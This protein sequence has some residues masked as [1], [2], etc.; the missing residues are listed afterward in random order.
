MSESIIGL[1]NFSGSSRLPVILQTESAECGLACLAMV[2]SYHG[3]VVDLNTLRR[4]FPITLRGIDLV[5]LIAMAERLKFISNPVRLEMEELSQ[6]QRPA[7]L[8]WDLNHFVVLKDIQAKYIEIHDPSQGLCKLSWKEFSKHFTGVAVEL[9]PTSEFEK[10]DE[11]NTL[12]LKNFIKPVRG[13][14][15][16][17]LKILT[18]SLSLQ[19]FAVLTPF[20]MQWVVDEAIMVHDQHLVVVLSVGFLLLMLINISTTALRSYVVLYVSNL[21]SIQMG[22]HLFNH[23]I[24]L[25]LQYFERRHMGDIV[26]RFGSLTTIKELLTSSL[27]ETLVDGLMALITLIV[28]MIYSPMLGIIVVTSAILYAGIRFAWYLPFRQLT[29]EGIVTKAKESSHFM[30][31]IRG[32]QS[33]KIFGQETPRQIAWQNRFADSLNVGIR[34]GKLKII[35]Q[36]IN[37]LFFGVQNILVVYLAANMVINQQFSVGMLFAFMSYKEQFGSRIGSLI[38]KYIELRMI[39]LHLERLS[40]IALTEKEPAL[41]EAKTIEPRTLG[42]KLSLKNISFGYEESQKPIF[43]S[44][45]LVIEPGES[46]AII[47]PSGCGKTT[48]MKVMMGLF[49]P[50]EGEVL[51]DGESLAQ[52]GI[53][54]FRQQV[55]AVMQNDQLLSGSIRDNI[56]FFEPACDQK[57]VEKAAQLAAIASD[58]DAMPMGYNSLIGD[59]GTTLSGGQKQ[60]VLLARALYRIPKILFLD[61]ATSHLDVPLERAVSHAVQHLKMTRIIVAH[62]PETIQSADRVL[63]LTPN[64]LVEQKKL[65]PLKKGG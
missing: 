22:V 9:S 31:S 23:I 15:P 20:Y 12:S 26:S 58:I 24:R 35:Y 33:I 50:T 34:V 53:Q 3:H 60:R 38:D 28:M 32:I 29:E 10:K 5:A 7:I 62:R 30:E 54:S 63:L 52:F 45:S 51:V 19:L 49:I 14:V 8:H 56:C 17:L 55:C 4:D 48:L 64:G 43:Q 1:L 65:P 44:V 27:V 16:S 11:K 37:A 47:G 6:L 18:L 36:S 25:P 57:Q 59:M 42:G 21:L 39:G 40:D 61:E 2:A 46:V 41:N 13:L